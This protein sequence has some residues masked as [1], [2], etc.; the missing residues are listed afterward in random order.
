MQEH[1]YCAQY[2]DKEEKIAIVVNTL[3][4]TPIQAIRDN[5]NGKVYNANWEEIDM[6]VES[7][8]PKGNF[9]N[10]YNLIPATRL[11]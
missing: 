9:I 7:K 1:K 2:W 3:Q 8:K 11:I 6:Q 5:T 10:E 4:P